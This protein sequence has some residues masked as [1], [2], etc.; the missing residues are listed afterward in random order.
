MK[1]KSFQLIHKLNNLPIRYVSDQH[2][3]SFDEK[4]F[5]VF[6]FSLSLS[7]LPEKINISK[8]IN[9]HTSYYSVSSSLSVVLL[10]EKNTLIRTLFDLIMFWSCYSRCLKWDERE[11]F[12]AFQLII[13]NRSLIMSCFSLYRYLFD[14]LFNHIFLME[15]TMK[16][17]WVL[18]WMF[19]FTSS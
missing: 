5:V 3:F 17:S 4:E 1:I 6:V 12:F 2:L 10:F 15:I 14:L 19:K 16:T 13:S 18:E 7:H 8:W 11:V 9:L